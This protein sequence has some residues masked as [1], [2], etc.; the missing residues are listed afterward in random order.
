MPRCANCGAMVIAGGVRDGDTLYCGEVC[1]HRSRSN[2]RSDDQLDVAGFRELVREL[3]DDVS[4]LQDEVERQREA[5]SQ[6]D[7]RLDFLERT[8]MQ[9]R[10]PPPAPR[11]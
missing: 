5:L 4:A 9:L 8:V 7:E 2:V 6:S 1:R 11:T 10:N 3:R